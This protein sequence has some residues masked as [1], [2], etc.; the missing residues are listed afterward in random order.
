MR[1]RVFGLAVLLTGALVQAHG[2]DA[3]V[4]SPRTNYLEN[5]GGCHGLEGH[6][7][8]A[9]VPDL[10]DRA[11]FF[12]CDAESRTFMAQLPN[13]AFAALSNRALAALLN[14][15]ALGLGG[16]SAPTGARPYTAA[17]V[18]RL[19]RSPLTTTNLIA[20]RRKI[21]RRTIKECGAP[22]SLLSDYHPPR[23]ARVT[24]AQPPDDAA[25][26]RAR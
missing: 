15:V 17:E 10:R 23:S 2:Q 5:C 4:F 7:T 25:D 8:S 18:A 1:R 6:S 11:G 9:L 20:L 19:R 22:E 14:Y 16:P 24:A 3:P 12:L 21:V 26:G 13:I